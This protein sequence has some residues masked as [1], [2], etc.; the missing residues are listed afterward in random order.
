MSAFLLHIHHLLSPLPFHSPFS[1]VPPELLTLQCQSLS[2]PPPSPFPV[3]S[4]SL[5]LFPPTLQGTLTL[6]V[7]PP[8]RPPHHAIRCLCSTGLRPL[9]HWPAYH[10]LL[11]YS[12]ISCLHLFSRWDLLFRSVFV[13]FISRHMT[14]SIFYH[15][16]VFSL[17]FRLFLRFAYC[18]ISVNALYFIFALISLWPNHTALAWNVV[19]SHCF[20]I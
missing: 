7:F 2:A 6:T 20:H 16:F 17:F 11:E 12:S 19:A 13:R 10:L 3:I 15:W 9:T 5:S 4:P 14:H 1:C 8:H 18:T